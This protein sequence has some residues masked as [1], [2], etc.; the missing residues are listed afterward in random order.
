MYDTAVVSAESQLAIYDYYNSDR[1]VGGH[2]AY[3]LDTR[4]DYQLY[5]LWH[6][7][8]YGTVV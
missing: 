2:F 4:F 3:S 5:F 6:T 1:D 8:M 7:W